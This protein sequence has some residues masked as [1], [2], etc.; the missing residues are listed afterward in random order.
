M[1][2]EP[3]SCNLVISDP[4]AMADVFVNFRQT[5]P[6]SPL[7]S[8]FL[9]C[10]RVVF[11]FLRFCGDC[12]RKENRFVFEWVIAPCSSKIGCSLTL[13]DAK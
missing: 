2:D 1:L 6:P 9:M 12:Q 5:G 8:C 3:G 13:K 7:L 10:L 4:A 11:V